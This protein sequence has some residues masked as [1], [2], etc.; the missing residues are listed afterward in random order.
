[1]Y[2]TQKNIKKL[3]KTNLKYHLP[4]YFK[5]IIKIYKRET[6]I[7]KIITKCVNKIENR[8]TIKTET[9]QNFYC[10]K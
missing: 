2:Y 10:L 4:D 7:P 6:D 3:K 5:Y 1:M 8:F 9:I